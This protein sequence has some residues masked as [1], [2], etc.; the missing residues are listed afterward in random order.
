MAAQVWLEV[1]AS[2]V[3]ATIASTG[4][5]KWLETRSAKNKMTNRLLLSITKHN[6]ITVGFKYIERGWITKD[7]YDDFINDLYAPYKDFG[8]NGLGERIFKDVEKL[9][10]IGD[11]SK[12][13]RENNGNGT[14]ITAII[15]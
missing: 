2:I 12:R 5:W 14:E 1:S 10:I 4:F 7:E 15:Q 13:K 9:P 6:I 8:G 11:D 3:I